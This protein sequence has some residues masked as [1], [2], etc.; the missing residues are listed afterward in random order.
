MAVSF[1]AI[2]D[3][4]ILSLIGKNMT[5]LFKHKTKFNMRMNEWIYSLIFIYF[6]GHQYY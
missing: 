5:S 1:F 3:N 2:V 6:L 4:I